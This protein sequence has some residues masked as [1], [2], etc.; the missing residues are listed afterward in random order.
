MTSTIHQ[1]S[2]RLQPTGEVVQTDIA[3]GGDGIRDAIGSDRFDVISLEHGIDLWVDDE[4]LRR[5]LIRARGSLTESSCIFTKHSVGDQ[6]CD[7]IWGVGA[8]RESVEVTERGAVSGDLPEAHIVQD[9]H[10]CW[11]VQESGELPLG[12]ES[13]FQVGRGEKHNARAS[14]GQPTVHL[15]GLTLPESHRAFVEPDRHTATT[16]TLVQRSSYLPAV[17]AGVA[18]E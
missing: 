10:N 18:Q 4:G 3:A 13:T 14:V 7:L 15:Q 1:R 12:P 8:R 9:R 11:L 2:I 6:C 16:Q 17:G 5:R